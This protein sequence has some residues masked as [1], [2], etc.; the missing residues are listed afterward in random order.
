MKIQHRVSLNSTP[1]VGAALAELGIVTSSEN[2]LASR[3]ITF[4]V[5]ED[6]PNW[7]RIAQ[8]ID[9]TGAL[10]VVTTKFTRKEIDQAAHVQLEPTWHHGYPQ[11][12]RDFGYLSTTYDLSDYCAACGIGARQ[13]SSFQM[14]G[15][16]K[17]GRKSILQLNWVFDE[18]FVTPELWHAV[19]EPV[20]VECLPVLG[21]NGGELNT[22]VQLVVTD[23]V[24]VEVSGLPAEN[25]S[26]CGRVKYP[27]MS[28][29]FF[30]AVMGE[31]TSLARTS[32]YFGSGASAFRPVLARQE[33][34]RALSEGKVQGV[35]VRPVAP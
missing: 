6:Q 30:P 28:R 21:K 24:E 16:P 33:I 22:V 2:E 7:P 10:D 29:G 1:R 19:F 17:W 25:C 23:E 5:D 27:P 18:F 31:P 15:E 12:E 13:K 32:Q 14:K 9:R 4:I 20:G 11:P 35:S 3:M 34:A 8:L 26:T